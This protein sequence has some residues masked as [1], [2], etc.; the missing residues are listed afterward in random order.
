MKKITKLLIFTLTL[1]L[2]LTLAVG[3]L[4]LQASAA[5][6]P[7]YDM[8]SFRSRT[9]TWVLDPNQDIGQQFYDRVGELHHTGYTADEQAKTYITDDPYGYLS[10]SGWFWSTDGK[11]HEYSDGDYYVYTFSCPNLNTGIWVMRE[12]V[13]T[14]RIRHIATVAISGA[15]E[16]YGGVKQNGEPVSSVEFKSTDTFSL[17]VVDIP[18]H[19]ANVSYAGA[20]CSVSGN[21]YTFRNVNKSFTFSVSYEA[22][23]FATVSFDPPT[24]V[25]V[26]VNGNTTS[27]VQVISGLPYTVTLKA[28][29]GYTVSRVTLGGVD[30]GVSGASISFSSNAGAKNETHTLAV[31]A[32]AVVI[33]V[34]PS[35]TMHYDSAWSTQ[36]V[37]E[38]IYDAIYI[39]SSGNYQKSD[40]HHQIG[41]SRPL[42]VEVFGTNLIFGTSEFYILEEYVSGGNKNHLDYVKGKDTIRVRLV[43]GKQYSAESVISLINPN[44]DMTPIVKDYT[45]K[46]VSIS[47]ANQVDVSYTSSADNAYIYGFLYYNSNKERMSVPIEPGNY[48]V[49]A[50]LSEGR[51][52][53]SFSTSDYIPLTIRGKETLSVTG[54]SAVTGSKTYDGKTGAP[55]FSVTVKDKSTNTWAFVN[56]ECANF[57][58]SVKYEYSVDGTSFVDG[59]PQNAGSYTV[60]V[61]VAGYSASGS[62]VINPKEITATVTVGNKS[63]DGS[64]DATL[65]VN[66]DTGI[67]GELVTVTGVKGRFDSASASEQPITVTVDASNAE[68]QASRTQLSNYKITVPATASA[69]IFAAALSEVSVSQKDTLTY[70]GNAQT[71]TV[72]T[73]ATAQ[74]DQTVTFVYSLSENGEYGALPLLTNAGSYTVWYRANAEHHQ[75]AGGSFT[76]QIAKQSVTPPT[77]ADETE[78]CVPQK[79]AVAQS[80]LYSVKKNDGGTAVGSYEVILELTDPQNYAW[81]GSEESECTLSFEIVAASEGIHSFGEYH[82]DN[83]A[84]TEQ[85]GTKTARC[86]HCEETDTVTEVGS[87]LLAAPN[88]NGQSKDGE[89]GKEDEQKDGAETKISS[90]TIALITLGTVLLGG[91]G[92]AVSWVVIRKK[93][94]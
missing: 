83:N 13:V 14:L 37:V 59:L 84:T 81:Q 23:D 11:T 44:F 77:L 76:V 89:A 79:A 34:K 67:E 9:V 3:T 12:S 75:T 32:E 20:T 43:A 63:Y 68:Y 2:M 55:S 78:L 73:S 72:T 88:E 38:A 24:G 47:T 62:Y 69:P 36:K 30:Q 17:E 22:V 66:V 8:S 64:T 39:S 80:E 42:Q 1:A 74:D 4:S 45:G 25:T 58:F 41:D 16:G 92:A 60:R 93:K 21:V 56:G 15:P 91:G 49:R 52:L 29:K 48:Y 28:A 51:F 10:D 82:S 33:E 71:V 46:S 57:P 5:E 90:T 85:D 94:R 54:V 70:N 61:T 6:M 40:L 50:M 7:H 86:I 27:P 19:R 65:S 31:T 26:A 35:G 87:K 53:A 18:G